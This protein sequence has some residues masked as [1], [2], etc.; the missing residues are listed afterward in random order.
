MGMFA[1][2]VGEWSR[3]GRYRLTIG[4]LVDEIGIIVLLAGLYHRLGKYQKSEMEAQYRR[5]REE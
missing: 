5:E 3:A 4:I 1:L 2:E